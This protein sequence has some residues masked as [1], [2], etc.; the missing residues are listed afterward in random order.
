[1]SRE[2]DTGTSGLPWDELQR[3]QRTDEVNGSSADTPVPATLEP[4]LLPD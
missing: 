1:M 2:E 4:R 3:P